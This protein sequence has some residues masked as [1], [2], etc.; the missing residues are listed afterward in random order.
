MQALDPLPSDNYGVHVEN[1]MDH[2]RLLW[3]LNKNW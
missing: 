2:R 1:D 3:L